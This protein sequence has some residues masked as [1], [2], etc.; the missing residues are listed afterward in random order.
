[1]RN[2]LAR[3]RLRNRLPV[4]LSV[5]ALLLLFAAPAFAQDAPASADAAMGFSLPDLADRDTVSSALR[6]LAVVTVVSVAPA[7]AVLVT[8]FTRIIVVLGLLRQGLATQQSPPNSVL[9]GLS[10]LMTVAVMA[11]VLGDLQR[12]TLGPLATGQAEVAPA[13]AAGE[14]RVREFMIAQVEAAG[15]SEDVELFL[16]PELTAREDLRWK[17]VP[18]ASLLPGFVISE[19]KVAFLIGFRVLLPFLIVDMVVASILT[20]MGMLM[21]P[22]VLISLPFKLLLFV[23]AD[24]WHLVVGTLLRSFS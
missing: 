2:L 5:L 11:P 14:A 9:F 12:D 17:D 16:D 6:W 1:M 23:L 10:L 15:N 13:L 22:P 19:L 4:Q 21:L 20:S 7:V 18:T 8:S 24:G 3:H